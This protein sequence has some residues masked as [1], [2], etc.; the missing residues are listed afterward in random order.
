MSF[1]G[2][3]GETGSSADYEASQKHNI[4]THECCQTSDQLCHSFR[5]QA[6]TEAHFKHKQLCI[7]G[8]YTKWFCN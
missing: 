2:W 3:L 8:N 4:S 6:D 7:I 5:T 1:T